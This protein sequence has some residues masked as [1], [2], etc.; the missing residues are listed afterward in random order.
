MAQRNRQ[1]GLQDVMELHWQQHRLFVGY[2]D[3]PEEHD[4]VS[5]YLHCVRS[6]RLLQQELYLL[7]RQYI[8]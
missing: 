5:L 2:Q 1:D 8:H 6:L 3:F 4:K 7:Q